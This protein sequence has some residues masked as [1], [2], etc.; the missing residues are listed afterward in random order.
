ML[1]QI[2]K[3]M[4]IMKIMQEFWNGTFHQ[5]VCAPHQSDFITYYVTKILPT[6]WQTTL[7]NHRLN[8]ACCRQVLPGRLWPEQHKV[9]QW[10]FW[11]GWRRESASCGR[12]HIESSE[13]QLNTIEY[14]D[15][16][17]KNETLKVI[18]FLPSTLQIM[19]K[20]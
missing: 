18:I 9:S 20:M 15:L 7:C 16:S 6:S 17:E 14:L 4:L 3:I 1:N 8:P 12:P 5:I 19:W 2:M 10:Y 11:L 13:I